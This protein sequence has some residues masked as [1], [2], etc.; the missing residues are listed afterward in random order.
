MPGS[1]SRVPMT[2]RDFFFSDPFFQTSW[3]DFDKV[4][5]EMLRE[6]RGFWD[7]VEKDMKRME[8]SFSSMMSSSSNKSI[9]Q[10]SQALENKG[11]STNTSTSQAVV[12]SGGDSYSPWFFPRRWMLPKLFGSEEDGRMQSLDLFQH[13]D[14]QVRED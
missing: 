8:N 7:G 11:A 6:S 4:K 13:K 9:Q 12:P 10:S 2:L 3:D 14:D 1:E 5:S